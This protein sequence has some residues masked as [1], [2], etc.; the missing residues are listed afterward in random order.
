MTKTCAQCGKTFD[1][2]EKEKEYCRNSNIPLPD[3]CGSCRRRDRIRKQDRFPKRYLGLFPKRSKKKSMGNIGMVFHGKYLLWS[4]IAL[5]VF[6]QAI[7]L[8]MRENYTPPGSGGSS[9]AINTASGSAAADPEKTLIFRNFDLLQE[10]FE[11]HGQDMGYAS[12]EEYLAA[13][14]AVVADPSV[15]HKKQAEDGDDVY[16][17]PKSNDLV[18]VSTDGYIRTYFRPEDGMEY[19]QRQ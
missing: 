15:L 1:V 3:C 2:S 4:L 11:K 19:Y 10:H 8:R 12:T 5:L 6:N 7:N 18:I 13:A 14:N 9:T 17:L 16:F